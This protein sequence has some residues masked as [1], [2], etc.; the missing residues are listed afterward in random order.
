MGI[1]EQLHKQGLWRGYSRHVVVLEPILRKMSVRGMPVNQEEFDKV[2]AHLEG[3]FKA[4]KDRMQELV[5]YEVKQKKVYK[6]PKAD[7]TTERVLPWTPSNQ[8]L[9]RYMLHR[10]HPVPKHI[11]TGRDT[12]NELEIIRLFRRTKDPLYAAVIQYRKSQTILKNHVKNWK[13]GPDQRVHTTFYLDPATGQLSSRR[14]NVQNAPKHDD[15]ETGGYAQVF[16]TMVKPPVGKTIMEFDYRAFHVQTLGFEAQDADMMRMGRLD[17][18]SFVTAHFLKLGD[19][20]RLVG[21][22]D[23]ELR[24]RLAKVK[25]EHK[26][27]R[28]A[29]CKHALLGY[30]NGIGFRKLYRQY[31]EF[32]QSEREAKTVIE[33]LDHLFPKSAAFKQRIVQQAHEQ[34]YLISRHGYIRYF[35]EVFRYRGRG[36]WTHGDDAEAA[37]CFFTQNDAHGEL[38]DRIITIAERGLDERYGLLNCIHDS[39]IFECPNEL[40]LDCRDEI[41][42]IMEE[43]SKVLIDPVV[44]PNGLSVEVE[45]VGGPDW[46]HMKAL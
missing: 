5:P 14:P 15:P 3:D 18:H 41:K 42:A 10:G 34:G 31:M 17:I 8:G 20:S 32:F 25:K 2:V 22:P 24:D 27:T 37:L 1:L 45:C 39:L 4:A 35:W 13:P 16:R 38:K 43:P 30:N 36:E 28:D 46:A 9:T 44:A 12:T 29:Q 11:K 21:L 6:R 7:G 33:L 19:A 23:D 40:V 26:H